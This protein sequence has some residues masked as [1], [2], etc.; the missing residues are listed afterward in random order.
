ME[1]TLL[2]GNMKMDRIFIVVKIILPQ[3]GPCRWSWTLNISFETAWL[4]ITKFHML[5]SCK[6]GGGGGGGG[7]CSYE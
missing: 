7:K 1:E 2:A 3:R 4:I 6:G 5:S